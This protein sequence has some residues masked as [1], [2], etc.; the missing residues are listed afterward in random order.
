MAYF[1]VLKKYTLQI[2]IPLE[3]LIDLFSSMLPCRHKVSCYNYLSDVIS[4]GP[5]K[6]NRFVCF[7]FQRSI[8]IQKFRDVLP[9]ESSQCRHV[10]AV[11][12]VALS[13]T[14]REWL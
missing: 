8:T 3:L 9:L 6:A 2:F 1:R 11:K 7:Y 13:G 5:D 14:K 4:L 10:G 12:Y